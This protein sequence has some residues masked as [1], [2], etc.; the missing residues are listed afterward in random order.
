MAVS[1]VI[2]ANGDRYLYSICAS[3]SNSQAGQVR[4]AT[5]NNH[6]NTLSALVLFTPPNDAAVRCL[7]T[8]LDLS[9]DGNFLLWASYLA[10]ITERYHLLDITNPGLPIY[11]PFDIP[12]IGGNSVNDF[13]GVEFV[14]NG[15][16]NILYL[17]AGTNGIFR[18]N[19]AL[20]AFTQVTGS[21][22]DYGLSQIELA[23]NG[24]MYASSINTANVGLIN[25]F[26]PLANI[27]AMLGG[28][29]A[30]TLMKNNVAIPCPKF[31]SAVA[32]TPFPTLPDQ[33]DGENYGL[34]LCTPNTQTGSTDVYAHNSGNATWSYSGNP[35]SVTNG[36]IQVIKELRIE[37][38]SHLTI[39]NMT[40]KFSPG[41]KVIIQQGST[42]TLDNGTVFTSDKIIAADSCNVN[43]GWQGIEVWG[44]ANQP[45]SSPTNQ[46]RLN[47]M[48]NS[49]IEYARCGAKNYNPAAAN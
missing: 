23:E 48:H 30:F 41:A 1:S 31:T 28:T 35:W 7:T 47:V 12:G 3:G 18:T 17:G 43:D 2:N 40:F 6:G 5:I 21:N 13:R 38:N 20:T 19:I 49:V 8:E 46:G 27:P 26:N 33:I 4:R 15:G 22:P 34:N 39:S 37:N 25:A 14:S 9:P 24:L 32:N 36:A 45:Q 10:N 11:H 29:K 42:L 44:T 16:N